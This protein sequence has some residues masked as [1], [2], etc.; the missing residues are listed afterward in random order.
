MAAMFNMDMGDN[1]SKLV[2]LDVSNFDT[3]SVENMDGLFAGISVITLRFSKDL[4]ILNIYDISVTFDVIKFVTSKL[5]V[6]DMSM[7]F[8]GTLS[9]NNIIYGDNFIHNQDADINLML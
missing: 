7:M 4:H 5:F 6:L 3:S 8:E 2:Y 1:N 9:L